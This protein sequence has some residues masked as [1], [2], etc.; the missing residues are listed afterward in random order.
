MCGPAFDPLLQAYAARGYVV[1]CANP[2]GTP[3][4]GEAFGNLLR[5]RNPGDR[6]DDL[7]RGVHAVIAKGYIDP[8]RVMLCGG[9]VSAWAIGQ[10][11]RFRAV[12]ARRPGAFA[13]AAP[14]DDPDEYVKRSPLSFAREFRTPTLVL[15]GDPDPGSELLYAALQ[16][17]R[18]ESEIIRMPKPDR[19]GGRILEFETVLAWFGKFGS[20]TVL[21]Q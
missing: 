20:G 5:T 21:G 9:A 8:Q 1:L 15:A 4:Y 12:V 16:A 18:V 11:G 6:F 19:P 7:S 3:G 17:R 2:R 13:V 10:T 14:W